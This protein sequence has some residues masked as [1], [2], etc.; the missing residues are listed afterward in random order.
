MRF[1]HSVRSDLMVRTH[2]NLLPIGHANIGCGTHCFQQSEVPI[3]QLGANYAKKI[4]WCERSIMG[5]PRVLQ[6]CTSESNGPY[7]GVCGNQ[8]SNVMEMVCM[9]NGGFF[10][11]SSVLIEKKNSIGKC[12]GVGITHV[13]YYYT[14]SL[15]V[16]QYKTS[17]E[18]MF[19]V[20]KQDFP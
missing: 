20:I 16:Y 19:S 4:I 7:R 10:S 8:L 18:Y 3:G 2:N 6:H 14:Q 5:F 11:R 13:C 17:T 15:N 1:R 12:N 9:Y